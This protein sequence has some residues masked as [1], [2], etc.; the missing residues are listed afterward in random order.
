MVSKVIVIVIITIITVIVTLIMITIREGG[1]NGSCRVHG[2]SKESLPGLSEKEEKVKRRTIFDFVIVIIINI[3]IIIVI[4]SFIM[5]VVNI[6]I[7]P[8]ATY[9]WREQLPRS[10]PSLPGDPQG[11]QLL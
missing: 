11:G 3:N 7:K 8:G 2:R 10:S 9:K 1:L 6:V 4:I 5:I